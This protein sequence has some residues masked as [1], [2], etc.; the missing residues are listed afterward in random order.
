MSYPEFHCG[1]IVTAGEDAIHNVA[2]SGS[3]RKR[4][5]DG[6]SDAVESATIGLVRGPGPCV[7][8]TAEVLAVADAR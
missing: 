3:G 4:H 1:G 2:G 8:D 5:V 7:G 6:G